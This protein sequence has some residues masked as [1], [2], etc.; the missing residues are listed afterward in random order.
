MKADPVL[1]AVPNPVL[2]LLP[3][4]PLPLPKPV[5]VEVLPKRLGAEEV[6]VLPKTGLFWPKREVEVFDEPKPPVE[7]TS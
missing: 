1:P 2:V 4:P 7:K 3:N 5:V 6:L